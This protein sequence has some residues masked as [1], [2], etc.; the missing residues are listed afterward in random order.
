MG[1]LHRRK[2]FYKCVKFYD[3]DFSGKIFT[4]KT[5]SFRERGVFYVR[6]NRRLSWKLANTINPYK[7]RKRRRS[8]KAVAFLMKQRIKLYYRHFDEKK[9]RRVFA[10]ARH[11]QRKHL[12]SL[13]AAVMRLFER[14]LDNAV[15]RTGIFTP[16]QV[17][18][19]IQKY[20]VFINGKPCFDIARKLTTGDVVTFPEELQ[21]KRHFFKMLKCQYPAVKKKRGYRSIWNV[22]KCKYSFTL[23]VFKAGHFLIEPRNFIFMYGDDF[24]EGQAAFFPFEFDALK[25]LKIYQPV[26]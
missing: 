24:L 6:H 14:R 11:G 19:V 17:K 20:G 22:K 21:V 26:K 7:L 10:N 16:S 1:V 5:K 8:F 9:F 2:K 4:H 25:I 15:M 23:G 3:A 13:S 18:S 12:K